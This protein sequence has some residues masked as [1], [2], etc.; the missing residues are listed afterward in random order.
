MNSH[1]KNAT[2]VLTFMISSL[3]LSL[4]EV[5]TASSADSDSFCY[6][7]KTAYVECLEWLQQWEHAERNGL[8]FNVEKRFPL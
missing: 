2:E 3:I 7:E 8:N 6:G 4:E 5:S 1:K